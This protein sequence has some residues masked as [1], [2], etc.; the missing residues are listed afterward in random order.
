MTLSVADLF[1][2]AGGTSCGAELT[3]AAKVRF[4]VNHWAI[5]IE[6]HSANFPHARHVN[7]RLD[8]VHPSECPR[9]DL[10]FASP[11]CTHHSKARGGRP[12][13]DQRRAG[14]WDVLKWV[15]HHRPSWVCVENVSEFRDWGPLNDQGR[16]LQSKKGAFF[17]SWLMAIQAAGYRVDH[18]LLNAADF[19]A[20]TS[21]ERL[22]VVARKG[23]RGPVFPDPTHTQHVG[24]ELPGMGLSRWRPAA[25]VIDW[26]IPCPS[27]F[28][29]KKPL[30]DKTL[31]RIEAGLRRF[32]GPYLVQFNEGVDRRALSLS[33]PL[34]TVKAGGKAF[35][36]AVPFCL[37]AAS[38]GAPRLASSQPY[39]TITTTCGGSV[40]VP[41]ITA[42]HGGPDGDQR[43]YIPSQPIPTLDTSNRYGVTV[44][45]VVEYYGQGGA[46]SVADPLCTVT[47]HDRCGLI[48]AV[49]QPAASIEPRS[50][51]ERSL[52]ATM[53]ELGVA[54]IGFRM[55]S[56]LELSAAQSFPDSYIF[57]GNKADVTKQIGNAVCP[58]VAQAITTAILGA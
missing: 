45:F 3:G 36:V 30:A 32:V 10:L 44:P 19:G 5:A 9:I 50:E 22:F 16:P 8:Q 33:N 48:Y 15:E 43:N 42:F 57:A 54:D 25:E 2:G 35:G 37:S 23:N 41:F 39:P 55:L 46:R 29:R 4:A 26:S 28:S 7:S 31:A 18:Q 13:C 58:V 17:D 47:T 20:A 40:T 11:E 6:T 14:A 49:I 38:C 27:V 52:I 51:G 12:M 21:R 34:P 56:N 1:C 24:G 53:R